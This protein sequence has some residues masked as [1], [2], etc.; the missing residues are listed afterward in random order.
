MS[1]GIWDV[2]DRAASERPRKRARTHVFLYQNGH[3]NI[4]LFLC[5]VK[6]SS[7]APFL[8]PTSHPVFALCPQTAGARRYT[9]GGVNDVRAQ[10][11]LLGVICCV[12]AS[13]CHHTNGRKKTYL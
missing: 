6:C 1:R 9:A 13:V 4:F 2:G 12:S 3:K 11:S 5:V 10:C 8:P 7:L